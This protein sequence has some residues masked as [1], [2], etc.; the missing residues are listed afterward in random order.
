[1]CSELTT[2]KAHLYLYVYVMI[3]IATRM[4]QVSIL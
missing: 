3:I 4:S 1:M 2:V